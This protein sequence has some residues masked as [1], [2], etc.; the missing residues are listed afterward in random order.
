MRR[1]RRLPRPIWVK[2]RNT[3]YEHMFS[4][5]LRTRTLR[6]GTYEAKSLRKR[7]VRRPVLRKV[8][9]PDRSAFEVRYWRSR[10]H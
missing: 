6:S 4:G 7:H 9:R 1:E 10:S 3:R 2:R 8:G 5:L